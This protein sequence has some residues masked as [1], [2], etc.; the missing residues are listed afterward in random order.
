MNQED[1][2]PQCK[3]EALP[4]PLHSYST[5]SCCPL[6]GQPLFLLRHLLLPPQ[7]V[8]LAKRLEVEA[9]QL[10]RG[11]GLTRFVGESRGKRKVVVPL[12]AQVRKLLR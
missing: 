5:R 1:L 3:V 4:R 10:M 9:L 7:S 2:S 8:I 11:A 6:E 12:K